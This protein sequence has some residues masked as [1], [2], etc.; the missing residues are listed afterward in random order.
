ML[1]AAT[2]E[3]AAVRPA[4]NRLAEAVTGFVSALF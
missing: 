4:S 1:V 2:M 3:P